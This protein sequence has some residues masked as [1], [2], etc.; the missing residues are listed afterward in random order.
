MKRLI[1]DATARQCPEC[2]NYS[3]WEAMCYYSTVTEP[4]IDQPTKW[5]PFISFNSDHPTAT[6]SIVIIDLVS[7]KTVPNMYYTTPNGTKYADVVEGRATISC[8]HENLT[9][10]T[11]HSLRF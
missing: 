8:F 10:T 7:R 6:T 9:K 2:A 5:F 4:R 3:T 11:L 1:V